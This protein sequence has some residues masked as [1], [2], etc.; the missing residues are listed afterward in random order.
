MLTA[1]N[2][3]IDQVHGFVLSLLNRFVFNVLYFFYH[4]PNL[5]Q[6]FAW[7]VSCKSCQIIENCIVV[8]IY[9]II[10]KCFFAIWFLGTPT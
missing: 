8:E 4:N 3:G 7:K 9:N 6:Y 2:V 1:A 10:Q 5:T